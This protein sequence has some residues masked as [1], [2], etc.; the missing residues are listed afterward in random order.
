MGKKS[1]NYV[2]HSFSNYSN[3]CLP[4][5]NK[6]EIQPTYVLLFFSRKITP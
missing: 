3:Y 4:M 2:I 1:S 5:W 6:K